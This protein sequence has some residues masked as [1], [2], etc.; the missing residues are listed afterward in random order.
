MLRALAWKEW[1]EQRPV[2]YTGVILAALLPLFL[3][4]GL[5]W[6][7]PRREMLHLAGMIPVALGSFVWPLLAAAAGAATVSSDKGGGTLGY[8]LSRPVSRMRLW[9][10][11]VTV[12]ILSVVTASLISLALAQAYIFWLLRGQAD[13]SL[14]ALVRRGGFG[15]P[16]DILV[17]ASLSLLLFA[18]ATFFSTL[19][20]RAL[21]AA[22]S[23]GALALL[24][25]S[26]ILLIWAAFSLQPW[27]EPQ[28]LAAEMFLAAMTILL[29]SFAIF[30]R[31]ELLRPRFGWQA[32]VVAAGLAAG[33][34]GL[35]AMPAAHTLDR[36]SPEDVAINGDGIVVTDG[37]VVMAVTGV[38]GQ[39]E[40]IWMVRADGS[41]TL[42]ISSRH[43]SSPM[44][45]ARAREVFYF[46][47][48]GLSGGAR[49]SFDLRAV[50]QDGRNDRLIVAGLPGTG[51][52]HFTPY[53]RRALLAVDELLYVIGLDGLQIEEHFLSAPELDGAVLAGWIDGDEGEIL[54]VRVELSA[55]EESGNP[56]EPGASVEPGN[57]ANRDLM[58]LLA[59]SLETG[60]TRTIHT[61]AV[62]L[63]GYTQPDQPFYGW[64]SFPVPVAAREGAD[65][66]MRIDLVDLQSGQIRSLGET[67]CFS[68]EL[69]S[70]A[71]LLAYVRC[72]EAPT[73]G[74]TATV[75]L[76]NLDTGEERVLGEHELGAG[77]VRMVAGRGLDWN[78]DSALIVLSQ[79]VAPSGETIAV[80]LGPDGR[81]SSITPG[82]IPIGLSGSSRVLLV[83][84]L[85]RI[86]TIAS[87]DLRTG[88][89]QVIFP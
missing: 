20:A 17:L 33:L 29:A 36:L 3:A 19:L 31:A 47:T 51:E 73:G 65:V 34:F 84:D 59:Y 56:V 74:S 67:A 68:G 16:F 8:L 38:S 5:P 60:E 48:R 85:D 13:T 26:G 76:R 81:R 43:A 39:G 22:V 78:E 86:R 7:G 72:L 77:A 14:G 4:V 89:L 40:E 35:V 82:W 50:T 6:R 28:W 61:S 44:W 52:L 1:R 21:P 80:V 32:G 37:G 54:F 2:V 49:D 69:S 23:G 64:R 70:G 66:A 63:A 75:L 24:V 9:V 71:S 57:E 41:G 87:G 42:P 27:L 10:I 88:V 55:S 11:K 18:C 15:G 83:D 30:A 62:S 25:L 46:S 45:A 58:T 12:A 79:D 53:A